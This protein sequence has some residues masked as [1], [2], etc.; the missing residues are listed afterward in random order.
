[1]SRIKTLVRT[2]LA[3][4]LTYEVS[5]RRGRGW[6]RDID[7]DVL[8]HLDHADDLSDPR[9]L[10]QLMPM[11]GL[12]GDIPEL[13]PPELHWAL[14]RG[15]KA[16]QYPCQFAPYLVHIARNPVRSYLEIGVMHGG[17]FITTVEYLRRRGHPVDPAVA[18][19]IGWAPGVARYVKTRPYAYAVLSDSASDRFRR[20]ARSRTWDVALIDGDH[21]FEG[22][23][24][25]FLTL[26]GHA[27]SVAFHDIL[28]DLPVEGGP[29]MEVARVWEHVRREY[30]DEYSFQEFTEQYDGVAAGRG[31]LGIGLATRTDGQ[32]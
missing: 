16:W 20:L 23:L 32:P 2:R 29:P 17:S 24:R 31:R 13:F 28:D 18:V 26:H 5:S 1:V 15:L 6:I 9:R 10:E 11:L 14:G 3:P 19:D 7:L 12:N 27:R 4:R 8:S 21:S 25:D 30:A 22:C